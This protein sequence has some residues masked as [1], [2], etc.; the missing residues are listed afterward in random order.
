MTTSYDPAGAYVNALGNVTAAAGGFLRNALINI[1]DGTP[2][3]KLTPDAGTTTA[4]GGPQAVYRNPAEIDTRT[5]TD[6]PPRTTDPVPPWLKEVILN[7]QD[8][9]VIKD[10]ALARDEGIAR[11]DRRIADLRLKGQQEVTRRQAQ[12]NVINAWKDVEVATIQKE[13]DMALGLAEIAYRSSMPNPAVMQQLNAASQIGV[14]AFG[15]K[16]LPVQ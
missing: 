8:P 7:Q 4:D 16:P 2:N 10:I 12:N 14:S 3:E 11:R 15:N 13:R 5:E 6:P 1:L 9:Q